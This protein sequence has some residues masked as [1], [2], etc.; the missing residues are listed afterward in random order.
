[1]SQ[2]PSVIPDTCGRRQAKERTVTSL[3]FDGLTWCGLD[4]GLCLDPRGTVLLHMG[5][6]QL[7]QVIDLTLHIFELT[8]HT[9]NN[10]DAGEIDSQV[11]GQVQ[12]EAELGNILL[13]IQTCISSSTHRRHKASPLVETECLRVHAQHLGDAANGKNGLRVFCHNVCLA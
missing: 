7:P 12:D 4:E 2:L 10:L 9:K 11:A 1:M 6:E 3:Y 13:G 8:L 5:T